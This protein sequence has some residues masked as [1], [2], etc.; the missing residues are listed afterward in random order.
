MFLLLKQSILFFY[1]SAISDEGVCTTMLFSFREYQRHIECRRT[2]L[3]N[4]HFPTKLKYDLNMPIVSSLYIK[5]LESTH[6]KTDREQ[7]EITTHKHVI[8]RELVHAMKQC[9]TNINY[10]DLPLDEVNMFAPSLTP[11][12]SYLQQLLEHPQYD[13]PSILRN[14]FYSTKIGYMTKPES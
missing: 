12:R 2:V 1:S 4:M 13:F 7:P 5:F 14:D 8:P 9:I 3:A 10:I 11:H 6:P